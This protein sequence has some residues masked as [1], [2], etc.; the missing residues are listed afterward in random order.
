MS[1]IV[2]AQAAAE[3]G[4]DQQGRR[5]PDLRP[6]RHRPRHR[7][8]LPGRPVRPGH[9]PP[10]R[11]R[12]H[13]A[14]HHVPRHRVRRSARAHRLRG[15]LPRPAVTETLDAAIPTAHRRRRDRPRRRLRLLA[16]RSAQERRD[17]L[18]GLSHAGRGVHRADRGGR[19]PSTSTARRRP[20]RSSPRPTSSSS[21]A[22]A[23]LIV[24]GFLWKFG[25]PGHQGRHERPDRADPGRPRRCRSAAHRGLRRSS[26][27][28]RPSSLTPARSRPASSRR[29]VRPP[30]R[31]GQ[32]CRPRPRPTSTSSRPR[33]RPTSKLPR[34]QAVADLRGEVTALAIGA[35]EQVVGRNLDQETNAAL[36]EA[37]I[38]QVGANS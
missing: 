1:A 12:R 16:R 4:I 25:M 32:A 13:G 11:V 36:V 33:R 28:T 8:R 34:L 2:L 6:R 21:V 17:R 31:C 29:P 19:R 15:V 7:H 38:N 26:P 10:A 18:R 23:F 20:T 9:G 35:A 27:S 5:R 30:T 24:F 14:H 3:S 22:S 37:Y